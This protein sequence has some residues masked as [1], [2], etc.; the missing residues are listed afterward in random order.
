MALGGKCGLG[1]REPLRYGEWYGLQTKQYKQAGRIVVGMKTAS[2]DR[3]AQRVHMTDI[4]RLKGSTNH[5]LIPLSDEN[6][7]VA[8]AMGVNPA[9]TPV[10]G[11]SESV[12]HMSPA[13]AEEFIAS[14]YATVLKR[15]PTPEELAHW[16]TTAG[17]LPPEQVFFPS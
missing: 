6:I 7:A 5:P 3:L 16:V 2:R 11:A 12:P 10:S 9:T 17:A 8:E 13:A 4:E 15:D 1:L 14:L